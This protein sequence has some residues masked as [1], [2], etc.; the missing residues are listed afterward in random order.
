MAV[1]PETIKTRIPR[2]KKPDDDC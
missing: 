1:K 2:R